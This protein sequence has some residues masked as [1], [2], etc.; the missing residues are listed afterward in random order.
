MNPMKI[1]RDNGLSKVLTF[2]KYDGEYLEEVAEE[3][4]RYLAWI[5]REYNLDEEDR[6]AI[7]E[8]LDQ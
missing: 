2:G 8:I 6:K 5:L 1:L 3:D 4:P 7:E